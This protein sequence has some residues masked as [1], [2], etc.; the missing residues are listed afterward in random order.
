MLAGVYTA[1]KKN[2]SIYYRSNITYRNK[3]I[4]LGSFDTEIKA[5]EA[6][7]AADALFGQ[8]ASIEDSFELT[9]YLPFDKLV[10][11]IN[12]RD[13]NMYIPTPVYLHKN[14]FSYYL[15]ANSELK[16]DIDDLFYYSSH[17]I[18]RR[19]GH[20][21]VN[22]YGMQVTLQSRYGIKSHAVCGRDYRFVNGDPSDFRYSNIEIINPYFGV[23]R[24]SKNGQFRYRAKIHI[25]G[26]Y[27][28]G[29]Y[30]SEIKAAIAYNKAVDLAH[31]AGIGKAFPENYIES[32]SASEYADTYTSVRIS[33]KYVDYLNIQRVA[34]PLRERS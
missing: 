9:R 17:K 11:V 6:Y 34:S 7:L 22:D 3:H 14:Y 24:V 4:S 10:S 33:Q 32:L 8:S 1:R 13:N 18:M 20:L 30:R 2:G 28:I 27:T 19:Q 31:Q 16:F 25:N 12:Y 23:T 21:F 5:H 26:N 15:D 29:T